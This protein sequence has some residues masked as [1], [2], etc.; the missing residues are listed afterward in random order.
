MKIRAVLDGK[1]YEEVPTVKVYAGVLATLRHVSRVITSL[2]VLL[3]VPSL[4]HLKR[5]KRSDGKIYVILDLAPE[6]E[7]TPPK[8]MRL[9]EEPIIA[10]LR[11]KGFVPEEYELVGV[12]VHDVP[13]AAPLTRAQYEKSAKYWPVNFHPVKKLEALMSET[14]FD[15]SEEEFHLSNMNRVAEE[16]TAAGKNVALVVDFENRLPIARGIDRVEA[17]PLQHA[18]MVAVDAVA[19][20]HEGGG[21]WDLPFGELAL[22]KN[23]EP[24]KPDPSDEDGEEIGPYLCTGY[25]LY[26]YKEPC[27]MCAMSLVHSRVKRIFF[28]VLNPK[29]GAL[30]S[31]C[32]IQSVRDLNHHYGVF[33]VGD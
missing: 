4:Q 1:Y 23:R 29:R 15:A 25:D 13:A 27:V 11:G 16:A 20:T 26:V 32:Q 5:V 12:E 33:H 14:I 19:S 21:A 30:A 6:T 18:I 9:E 10:A 24:K 3:P 31:K 7:E 22:V 28:R 2:N 8:R 17:H